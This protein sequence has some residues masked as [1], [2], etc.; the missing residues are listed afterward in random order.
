M[1]K[2]ID[3]Q[4]CCG[5]GACYNICPQ[6]A[7]NMVKTDDGFSYPQIDQMK[8]INCNLCLKVCPFLEYPNNNYA[9]PIF[10]SAANSNLEVRKAS[11]SGG[12]FSNFADIILEEHGV[13]FGAEF[14]N[15][16]YL[17]HTCVQNQDGLSKLRGSKYLQSDIGKTFQTAQ[18]YL[19]K[20]IKVLFC[21]TPCQIAGLNKYLNREYD[22][23][24]TV[25][26]VCHGVSSP[27]LF[28]DFLEQNCK[29]NNIN[30]ADIYDI[31]F[32][33]KGKQFKPSEMYG[34]CYYSEDNACLYKSYFWNESFGRA[35]GAN[36][37][38]RES[39]YN[40]KYSTFPR[41]ADIS[42]G[43]F[44]GT[45]KFDK[46]INDNL[47]ISIVSIN[48]AKGYS[49]FEKI[50]RNLLYYKQVDV[51]SAIKY[52][53]NFYIP[54]Y[55]NENRNDFFAYYSQNKDFDKTV[56]FYLN[57]IECKEN[58]VGILCFT[59]DNQNYGANMVP[60]AMCNI[61]KKMGYSPKV[62]NFYPY[63]SPR[64]LR[65]YS[66]LAAIKFREN[67]VELTPKIKNAALLENLNEQFG[68]FIVGSDQVW[69]A[70]NTKDYIFPYYLD[71]VTTDKNIISYAASFGSDKPEISK[72]KI[73]KIKKLLERF[74]AI[75]VREDDGV[76][77][78]HKFFSEKIK[79]KSVLDPTL[80]VD[81]N[82]YEK[83][84]NSEC[85]CT[86]QENYIG[87]YLLSNDNKKMKKINKINLEKISEKLNLPLI[88]VRGKETKF[89]GKNIF[90]YNSYPQ[91]LNDIK[92]ASFIITDS[93]HGVCFSIIFKKN[94]I[95]INNVGGL[96]RLKSLL[97]K[98]NL[99]DRIYNSFENVDIS[100]IYNKNI[101]YDNVYKKLDIFRQESFD[102]LK[103]ALAKSKDP[104]FLKYKIQLKNYEN[105]HK[106]LWTRVD[107]KIQ[108]LN[109]YVHYYKRLIKWGIFLYLYSLNFKYIRKYL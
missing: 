57:N 79:C 56:D 5:C 16:L 108:K 77:L 107:K 103:T 20:G 85:L 63:L 68:T 106:T 46:N 102:F 3:K 28:Q 34:Y 25:D 101:D 54:S 97:I 73:N 52:N 19:T 58:S 60:F 87:Y 74:D 65:K 30:K 93:F 71:F 4:K 83:I 88:N 64:G 43:D 89:L 100:D 44:L 67:F 15:N 51:V 24:L 41:I 36:L 7:I 84:I 50:K 91:W 27:G 45:N 11:S 105:K 80:L 95:Y 22:N 75:S 109:H 61:I 14:N 6:G 35:F 29:K 40:C 33:V 23:L 21:G 99:E 98:L 53:P 26:L 9:K 32:R 49:Y 55:K 104:E 82:E 59:Y 70:K 72:R 31:R 8:C 2:L 78:I 66:L 62:I 96:N 39:C 47:G 38:L 1:D 10:Y 42:I 94:F 86:R 13:I 90:K 48:N 17:S 37:I 12:I 81:R 92:S 69:N 76:D 18:D